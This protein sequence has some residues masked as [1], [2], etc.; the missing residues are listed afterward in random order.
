MKLSRSVLAI[1]LPFWVSCSSTSKPVQCHHAARTVLP[2]DL[3]LPE[4]LSSLPYSMLFRDRAVGACCATELVLVSTTRRSGELFEIL[5][6][7]DHGELR[8]WPDRSQESFFRRRLSSE[9]LRELKVRLEQVHRGGDPNLGVEDGWAYRLYH[10][11]EG[12]LFSVDVEDP[13]AA[14]YGDFFLTLTGFLESAQVELELVPPVGIDGLRV[15]FAHPDLDVVAAW[16][17]GADVRVDVVRRGRGT[18]LAKDEWHGVVGGSLGDEV[19]EPPG[20]AL[21]PEGWLR[22]SGAAAHMA[23]SQAWVEENLPERLRG[24]ELVASVEEPVITSNRRWLFGFK[25]GRL[26]AL[27]LEDLSLQEV[28]CPH[29]TQGYVAVRPLGE[30]RVLYGKRSPMP[31]A[32]TYLLE[33]DSGVMRGFETHCEDPQPFFQT[34]YRPLQDAIGRA[35]LHVFVACP[36]D[37]SDQAFTV[38]GCYDILGF[39]MEASVRIPGIRFET[40]AMWV[41]SS[42]NRVFVIYSGYLLSLPLP[43]SLRASRGR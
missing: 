39:R 5:V 12:G 3:L 36:S 16:A 4:V 18:R 7:L 6:L 9:D 24:N 13:S 30:D 42:T 22:P 11:E 34:L 17:H 10:L 35:P 33:V 26:V 14:V 41:D 20:F 37:Y 27:R 15:E 19:E 21:N 43:E 28:R 2:Y 1:L 31:N 25:E 32:P 38:V 29:P 23:G 8:Y 40:D